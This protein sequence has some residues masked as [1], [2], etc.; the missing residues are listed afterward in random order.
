AATLCATGVVA[1]VFYVSVVR[2][3]KG[4]PA[5]TAGLRP[6]QVGKPYDYRA[7]YRVLLRGP[8]ERV[9]PAGTP[10]VAHRWRVTAVA[11]PDDALCAG[12]ASDGV[13]AVDA[14]GERA[15]LVPLPDALYVPHAARAVP[16]RVLAVCA[17]AAF[18]GAPAALVYTE[19]VV[20]PGATV[21]VVAC[22][23]DD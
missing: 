7:A 15:L 19:E 9:T 10:S 20:P 11:A 5:Y 16:P 17:D 23:S 18:S 8:A 4:L 22:L 21:E 2:A 3:A 13:A 1:A 14:S 12:A 6:A